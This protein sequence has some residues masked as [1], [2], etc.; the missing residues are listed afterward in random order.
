MCAADMVT[1]AHVNNHCFLLDDMSPSC[2]LPSLAG[3]FMS[4]VRDGFYCK[5]AGNWHTCGYKMLFFSVWEQGRMET[6]FYIQKIKCN[7]K[8]MFQCLDMS[9]QENL[10]CSF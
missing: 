6:E 9:V 5:K 4:K 1:R 7:N 10:G 8:C 2:P 3:L